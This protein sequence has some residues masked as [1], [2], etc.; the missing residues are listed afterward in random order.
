MIKQQADDNH[1]DGYVDL[2]SNGGVLKKVLQPASSSAQRIK[3]GSVV[4]LDYVG[5]L[6][7]DG[8]VFDQSSGYPFQFT[9]GEG[10]VIPGW[11][12]A[13]RSM[14]VGEK[15]LVRIR[16]D[17]AYG[18]EGTP[19]GDIPPKAD[20]LFEMT[21]VDHKPAATT[22]G[23]SSSSSSSSKVSADLERLAK[24]RAEREEA[25][26][27]REEDKRLKHSAKK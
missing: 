22:T 6:L 27:K 20:L 5:S 2:T 12:I 1:D 17:L 24:V 26:R 19:E 23:S 16:H 25:K 7:R 21:L 11:D 8:T 14:Q 18:D 10:K 13:V 9:V 15:S 4:Q 3:K